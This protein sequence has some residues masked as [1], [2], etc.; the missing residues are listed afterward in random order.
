[1][2]KNPYVNIGTFYLFCLSLQ[3]KM[4]NYG[5]GKDNTYQF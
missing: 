1:M 5:T 4:K 2:E 3:N